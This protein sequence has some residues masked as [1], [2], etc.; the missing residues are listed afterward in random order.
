M[1]EKKQGIPK[2]L[3]QVK[4]LI[5]EY[6]L[7]EAHHLIRKFEERG[8]HTLHDRVSGQVLNCELLLRQ[9]LYEDLVTLAE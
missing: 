3:I 1:S 9:G 2:E 6:K 5:V 7:D 4:Q 8:R